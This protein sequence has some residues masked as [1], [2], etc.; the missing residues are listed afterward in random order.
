MAK[1][2]LM[3]TMVL[4]S[5]QLIFAMEYT[6]E[7]VDRKCTKQVGRTVEMAL[8]NPNKGVGLNI[9]KSYLRGLANV[10]VFRAY[11]VRLMPT[12]QHL[13]PAGQKVGF[14]NKLSEDGKEV[15]LKCYT[16]EYFDRKMQKT[17]QR[18]HGMRLTNPIGQ[19]FSIL[20]SNQAA[21]KPADASV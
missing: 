7:E 14:E 2:F 18:G 1:K 10:D 16:L 6:P 9:E 20:P 15:I 5:G 17:L 12:F 13:I 4:L 21:S 3:A 19:A 8:T 11:V